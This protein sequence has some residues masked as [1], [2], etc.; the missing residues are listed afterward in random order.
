M[1]LPCACPKAVRFTSDQ[2]YV[3][4]PRCYGCGVGAL[5]CADVVTVSNRLVRQREAP[6]YML[7]NDDAESAMS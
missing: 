1:A 5:R 3:Q 7:A 2:I 6:K 4:I